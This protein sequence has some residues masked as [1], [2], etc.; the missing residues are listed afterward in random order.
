MVFGQFALSTC[1]LFVWRDSKSHLHFFFSFFF[2]SFIVGIISVVVGVYISEL[3]PANLRGG[4][5]ALNQSLITTGI[6]VSNFI[7]YGFA[8][9]DPPPSPGMPSNS[10]GAVESN[11]AGTQNLLSGLFADGTSQGPL[12]WAPW[13]GMLATAAIP[14][15][16]QL[17]SFEDR[18]KP[19]IKLPA[20][21]T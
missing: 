2:F 12:D 18:G 13:R 17:V 8:V 16:F 9:D 14:A 15:L 4:Y 5:G 1:P 19:R 10:T 7:G 20:S 21:L 3:S 6:F 11:G